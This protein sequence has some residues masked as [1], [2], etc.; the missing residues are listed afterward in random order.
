MITELDLMSV[1]SDTV[2]Y[3]YVGRIYFVGSEYE[4][5]II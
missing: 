1:N 3:F 4:E 2:L 5:I